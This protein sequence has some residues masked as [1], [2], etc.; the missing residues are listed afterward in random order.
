MV[1]CEMEKNKQDRCYFSGKGKNLVGT[2]K[3]YYNPNL[4]M[5]SFKLDETL[6]TYSHQLTRLL[7]RL[8]IMF[9]NTKA[10]KALCSNDRR[11]Y[12][13]SREAL[14]EFGFKFSD[15]TLLYFV[16]A[17]KNGEFKILV[18]KEVNK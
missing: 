15:N 6:I 12:S 1:L 17:N 7:Q 18:Y 11:L 14:Q 8:E 4:S 5:L 2:A 3:A 13:C 16:R 10:S 9:P